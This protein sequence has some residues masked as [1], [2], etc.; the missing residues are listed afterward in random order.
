MNSAGNSGVGSWSF[1]TNPASMQAT[2]TGSDN[3]A[4]ELE[5]ALRMIRRLAGLTELS[6]AEKVQAIRS[7]A[8]NA[9]R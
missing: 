7:I 2:N 5:A 4:L 8:E 3:K 9:T 1:I 6:A